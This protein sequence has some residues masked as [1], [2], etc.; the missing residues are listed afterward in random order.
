MGQITSQTF[1][2]LLKKQIA[3]ASVE[4][5]YSAPGTELQVEILVDRTRTRALGRVASLPF[6]DPPHKRSHGRKIQ[7]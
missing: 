3:I 4:S 7:L 1:S 5:E 2:P 6:Y